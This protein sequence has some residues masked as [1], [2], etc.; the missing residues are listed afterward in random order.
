MGE[1]MIISYRSEPAPSEN[2][3]GKI[4]IRLSGR[5]ANSPWTVDLDLNAKAEQRGLNVLW[6]REKISQLSQLKRKAK[7]QQQ[8]QRLRQQ[9]TDTAMVHHIVSQYTSLIAVDVTASRSA[10]I[11]QSEAPVPKLLP[12]GWQVNKG[13]GILPQTATSAQLRIYF[14][15]FLIGLFVC[16]HLLTRRNQRFIP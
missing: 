16:M 8:K 9:I 15:S 1:P 11:K 3:K 5:Q 12:K 4:A 6:A 2:S 10:N 7:D 13:A 14:G